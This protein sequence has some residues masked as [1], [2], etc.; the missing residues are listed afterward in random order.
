[1]NF[2]KAFNEYL[3]NIESMI[4]NHYARDLPGIHPARYPEVSVN[5]GR[6]YA[7]V[8][9]HVPG[10]W[11]SVHSFVVLETGDILKPASFNAPAKHAR[12]NIFEDGGIRALTTHGHIRYL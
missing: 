9:T 3:A 8:S 12:G 7:K 5:K 10:G 1:M 6:K 2:D 4:H 11:G